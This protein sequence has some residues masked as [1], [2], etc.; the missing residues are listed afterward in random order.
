[1]KQKKWFLI[2]YDVRDP[3]RLRHVAKHLSGY[4]VRIQYSLFRCCLSQREA[5]RLRWELSKILTSDDSLLVIGL[6]PNCAQRA[7]EINRD[8]LPDKHETFQ[9]L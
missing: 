5:E 7:R 8:A 6:C 1:M 9:I 3:K 2:S 4:G